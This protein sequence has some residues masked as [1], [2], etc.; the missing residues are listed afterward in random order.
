MNEKNNCCLNRQQNG[1]VMIAIREDYNATGKC[2]LALSKNIFD[3]Y[4]SAWMIPK[5]SKFIK[6]FN[7]GYTL[8]IIK[9]NIQIMRYKG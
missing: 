7:I 6:T 4:P 9:S 1:P 8:D 5:N 2:N 3:S